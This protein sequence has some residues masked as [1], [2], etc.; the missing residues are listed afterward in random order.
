ME[1]GLK[2]SR[3]GYRMQCYRVSPL[4]FSQFGAYNKY[5]L[6]SKRDL[7]THGLTMSFYVFDFGFANPNNSIAPLDT[8]FCP[9]V[10]GRD[11]LVEMVTGTYTSAPPQVLTNPAATPFGIGALTT[12]VGPNVSP[13]FLVNFLHTHQGVQRQWANKEITD[14]EAVGSG[15]YPLILK[16]PALLPE[17]D[18]ITCKIQNLAN[19]TLQAQIVF[20][21]AAFDIEDVQENEP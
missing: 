7:P 5:L 20:S 14:G 3:S 1:T 16:D 17:G 21:G 18:T 19:V 11:F 12:Q 9:L 4:L 2:F 10:L 15:D 6:P 8:A 13:G